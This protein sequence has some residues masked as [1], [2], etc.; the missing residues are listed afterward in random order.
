MLG[1]AACAAAMFLSAAAMAQADWRKQYPKFR[2]GVQSVETQAAS[3]TRYKGFGEYVKK[4]LGVEL[5]L[6]LASEYAGVI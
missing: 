3:L 4:K 5:E 6:F 1:S 2:Y